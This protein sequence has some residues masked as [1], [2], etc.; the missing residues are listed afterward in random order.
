MSLTDKQIFARRRTLALI[1]FA[2]VVALIWGVS[3]LFAGSGDPVAQPSESVT[4]DAEPILELVECAPGVVLIEA[5]IGTEAG[6][7][8]NSY[9]ASANPALWYSAT[10]TGIA[11]CLFNVGARVTFFTITSGE[12]T[13][14]SS[15]DCNRTGLIDSTVTLKANQPLKSEPSVWLKVRSSSEGC[16]EGQPAVPTGGASF[17][18]KAEVNGVISQNSQQFILN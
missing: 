8:R 12:E 2:L 6:E 18:I 5:F 17:F 10:N 13:Y 4:K 11:D 15:R 7:E 16:G 9:A 1:V 14:W 3:G